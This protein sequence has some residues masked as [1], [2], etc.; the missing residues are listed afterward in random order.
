MATAR[1]NRK[2]VRPEDHRLSDAL[3]SRYLRAYGKSGKTHH[4]LA[5]LI[6][7]P[8]CRMMKWRGNDCLPPQYHRQVA[9][10]LANYEAPDQRV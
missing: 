2:T 7:I 1:H 3:R 9:E 4:E 5:A 10:W 6:G 8:V